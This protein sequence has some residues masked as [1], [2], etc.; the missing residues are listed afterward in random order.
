MLRQLTRA[1][2]FLHRDGQTVYVRLWLRGRFQDWQTRAF[3]RF[4]AGV[5]EDLTRLFA[6]TGTQGRVTL[7]AAPPTW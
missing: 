2:G 6:P 4:L 5:S 1:D 3:Y 7:L